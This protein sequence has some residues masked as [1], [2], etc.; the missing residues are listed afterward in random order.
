VQEGVPAEKLMPERAA[1]RS[2]IRC[3]SPRT[4]SRSAAR[5]R[6]DA[7]PFYYKGV[8]DEASTNF[9]EVIE[10]VGDARLQVYL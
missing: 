5:A 7:A 10:R 9:A 3:A 4:P 1:A 8:S 2:P 6:A